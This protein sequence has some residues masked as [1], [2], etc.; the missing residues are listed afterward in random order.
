MRIVGRALTR[1]ERAERGQFDYHHKQGTWVSKLNFGT[2]RSFQATQH[3]LRFAACPGRVGIEI[4]SSDRASGPQREG[5]VLGKRYFG[6]ARRKILA[7]EAARAPGGLTRQQCNAGTRKKLST[8]FACPRPL[9]RGRGGGTKEPGDD[10]HAT[11]TG[12]PHRRSPG[13]NNWV[14]GDSDA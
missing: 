10:G 12:A 4:L 7:S 5:R 3:R 8:L 9:L 11:G 13:E 1:A 6:P 14:R 2:G